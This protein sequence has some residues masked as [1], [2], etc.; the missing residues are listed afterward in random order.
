MTDTR[1][2]VKVF[3]GS[4][5]DLKNERRIAKSVVDEFNKLWAESLGYHVELIGWED[6][7]SQLGR[8]QTIINRE[9][10]RCEL[11]IGMMFKRWGTPP[12]GSSRY[13]SGF[14]EEFERSVSRHGETGKPEISLL[15]RSIDSEALID[16]GQELAKV[17]AF[18][19]KIIANKTLLYEEFGA[20][21]EFEAKFRA[22]ITNYVP[23]AR[24]GGGGQ[25]IR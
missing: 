3:L 5:G 21:S 9:L 24:S 4:P 6:T 16:P 19:D 23:E 7:V 13:T 2:I 8:P 14:E 20:A 1:K 10:D 17:V 11:F 22:C 12:A 18:R 15:F 25:I